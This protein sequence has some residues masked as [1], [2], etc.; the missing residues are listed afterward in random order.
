MVNVYS[1][2]GGGVLLTQL[3]PP[4][5]SAAHA[6]NGGPTMAASVRLCRRGEPEI[7]RDEPHMDSVQITIKGN[8]LIENWAMYE[9]GKSHRTSL[10]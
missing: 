7:S 5:K 1:I 10:V 8:Q 6:G 2:D 4:G 9:G 3:L